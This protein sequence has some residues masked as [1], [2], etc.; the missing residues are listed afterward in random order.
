M[1]KA[2]IQLLFIYKTKNETK[3]NRNKICI[4]KKETIMTKEIHMICSI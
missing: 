3:I 2:K 4:Q 1:K